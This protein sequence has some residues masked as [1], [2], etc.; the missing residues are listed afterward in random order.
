MAEDFAAASVLCGEPEEG[1]EPNPRAFN[2]A[3][4]RDPSEGCKGEEY[5]RPTEIHPR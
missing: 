1:E 2:S 3:S 4:R 5:F